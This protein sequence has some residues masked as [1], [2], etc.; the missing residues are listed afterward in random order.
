MNRCGLALYGATDIIADLEPALAYKTIIIS[1]E[2]IAANEKVGYELTYTTSR[3]TTLAV[4]AVGYSNGYDKRFSNNS[5]VLVNY[6][7]CPVIGKVCMN[8]TIVDITDVTA[9]VGDEVILIGAQGEASVTAESLAKRLD[10]SAH[11][12]LAGLPSS[13]E[14]IYTNRSN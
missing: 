8:H 5:E 12:I 4:L 11:E 7:K 3:P 9:K 6:K 2:K 10:S 14:R 13:L 1:I